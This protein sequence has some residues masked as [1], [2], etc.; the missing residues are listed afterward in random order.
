MCFV[1]FT[2]PKVISKVISVESI[3]ELSAVIKRPPVIWDN[4]HANDYDQRRLF[5]GPYDGRSV[6]LLQKLRGVVT[7]PNCEYGANY[8]A[9][10]TLAQW[11]KCS[12]TLNKRASPT[13]QAMLLEM[14]ESP[15]L[16][17]L[18]ISSDIKSKECARSGNGDSFYDPK[19]ALVASLKDW[20]AEFKIPRRKP[21]HYKPVKDAESIAKAID[22]EQMGCSDQEEIGSSAMGVPSPP[23]VE[24]AIEEA[25]ISEQFTFKDLCLMVDYFFLPHQH[26]EQALHVLKEFCWLKEN[27]PGYSLLQ[28]YEKLKGCEPVDCVGGVGGGVRSVER[29]EPDDGLQSDGETCDSPLEEGMNLVDVSYI[30]TNGVSNCIVS[31]DYVLACEV[32]DHL[33]P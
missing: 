7:N 18:D 10:H 28:S 30:C 5:L 3:E 6:G 31:C 20:F 23:R 9:I 19:L 29:M 16:T 15:D 1:F 4:I 12:N 17:S 8:V 27:A 26:G 2:G 22:A 14:E 21:E 24:G 25:S 33:T 32:A 13:R 11:S